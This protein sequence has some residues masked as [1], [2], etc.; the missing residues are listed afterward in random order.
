MKS[1]LLIIIAIFTSNGLIYAAW[2]TPEQINA[3]TYGLQATRDS[4]TP[5]AMAIDYLGNIHFVFETEADSVNY[6]GIHYKKRSYDNSWGNEYSITSGEPVISDSNYL[7]NSFGHPSIVFNNY[8]RGLICYL[9]DNGAGAS[10]KREA[11][12]RDIYLNDYNQFRQFSFMSEEDRPY[13][14]TAPGALKVPVM[15]IDRN[16]L[17]YGFWPYLVTI[18][19]T[20]Y[21]QIY[22]RIYSELDGWM[23]SEGLLPS[24]SEQYYNMNS[25][26]AL[27]DPAGNI[28]VII[29]MKLTPN[30]SSIEV[31]HCVYDIYSETWSELEAISTPIGP[32]GHDSLLPYMSFSGGPDD[33]L[34]HVTW[35]ENY[36]T[37]R[38]IVYRRYNRATD[39]WNNQVIVSSP[40][41]NK[42]SVA[43]L[44][45]G[46][47]YV[48]WVDSTANYKYL[49]YKYLNHSTASWSSPV[50]L[51]PDTSINHQDSPFMITD[52]WDNLHITFTGYNSTNPNDEYEV[53]YSYYNLPP[54][55]P[56]NLAAITDNNHPKFKWSPCTEHCFSHYS[57][58]KSYSS[59]PKNWYF[60]AQTTDTIY[61]DLSVELNPSNPQI[62]YY[63]VKTVDTLNQVSPP[64]ATLSFHYYKESGK[65][66][67]GDFIPFD[68][69]LE[70]NYPN[71]FN[72][73]TKIEYQVPLPCIVNI[74]VFDIQ[75]KKIRMLV[76]EYMEPGN[77]SV[78]WNGS[79]DF[80]EQ[81]TSGIYFYK[82]GAGGYLYTRKMLMIK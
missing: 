15:A 4:D 42:P 66:V 63:Y 20:N 58:Y 80:G 40:S 60:E 82:M 48:A 75:G 71:P 6:L 24:I 36:P 50:Q 12:S 16:S 35:Q 64:S 53:F 32:D 9:M 7:H 19:S 70:Q 69:V 21:I 76:N 26:D 68:F 62:I 17:I 5:R 23:G 59:A 72:A 61:T 29:C 47:V 77:R 11:R 34:L 8:L 10:P 81:V 39:A 30:D 2:T 25:I 45:N 54:Q 13:L 79:D 56:I 55:A 22:W 73:E 65:W 28:H 3:L 46:D 44:S 57:I 1:L 49:Y 27:A 67:P 18:N 31:Y 52:K 37:Q 51:T 43:A 33:Y 74:D 14:P 41:A 78:I 38:K